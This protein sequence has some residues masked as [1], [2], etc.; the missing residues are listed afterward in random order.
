M[1]NLTKIKEY[2]WILPIIASF[3]A[4]LSLCIPLSYNPLKNR[5]Y[6]MTLLLYDFDTSEFLINPTELALVGGIIETIIVIISISLL[7]ISSLSIKLEKM[8]TI[9]IQ[10]LI[11]V[12]CIL[13]IF[14]PIA[15]YSVAAIYFSDWNI[16]IMLFGFIAPIIAAIIALPSIYLISR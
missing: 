2:A 8:K 4:I 12:S 14:I 3:F 16:Y 7:I 5:I 1:V 9:I 13:L 15:H 6:W 11:L 10:L